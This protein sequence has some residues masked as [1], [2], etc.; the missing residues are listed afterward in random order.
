MVV[1][2]DVGES[3]S[4]QAPRDLRRERAGATGLAPIRLCVPAFPARLVQL[5]VQGAASWNRG[6]EPERIGA[7]RRGRMTGAALPN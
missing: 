3:L 7:R 2:L 4:P 1:V 6:S 5:H